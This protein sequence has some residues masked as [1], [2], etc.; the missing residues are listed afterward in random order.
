MT[1]SMCP[2]YEPLPEKVRG[3]RISVLD[4]RSVGAYVHW[5]G[6]PHIGD[7]SRV[8]S[9]KREDAS[10]ISKLKREQEVNRMG[11]KV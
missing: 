3:R 1:R 8:L 6:D 7:I 5:P 9:Q 11:G 2:N 4:F 10:K